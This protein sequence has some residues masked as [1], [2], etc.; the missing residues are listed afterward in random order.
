MV[1]EH[2]RKTLA[3][4]TAFALA[5]AACAYW[6]KSEYSHGNSESL[7]WILGPTA[8]M[9]EMLF[10]IPFVHEAGIGW[11]NHQYEVA[12]APSCAGVNFLIILFCMSSFQ[13]ISSARTVRYIAPMIATTSLLAF[14]VTLLVNSL[15]IWISIGLYQADI[16]SNWLTPELVHRI[17]G[18]CVY[19]LFLY[20]YYLLVWFILKQTALSTDK[21][22]GIKLKQEFVLLLP[23]CWYLLFTIGIPYLHNGYSINP[24]QFIF[25]AL[26]VAGVS[27]ACTAVI[28]SISN[29]CKKHYY[30]AIE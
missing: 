22:F 14:G 17:G 12:I 27:T 20:F 11:L 21:T 13:V 8:S 29:M 1:K 18:V 7:Q 30:R 25:H 15:R 16:Y 24:D 3:V 6:L 19:Y 26:I 10:G 4:K 2:S 23:L 9:V 28:L 5:V